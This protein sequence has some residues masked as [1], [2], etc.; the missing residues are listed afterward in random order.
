MEFADVHRPGQ[1]HQLDLST[2]DAQA[3]PILV[4]QIDMGEGEWFYLAALL[5]KPDLL[6]KTEYLPTDR[7]LFL[8][9]LYVSGSIMVNLFHDQNMQFSIFQHDVF[10]RHKLL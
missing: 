9:F 6:V 4:A 5:P 10:C 8:G 7:L 3:P 1:L 2:V